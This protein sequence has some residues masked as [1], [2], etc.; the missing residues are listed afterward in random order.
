MSNEEIASRLH[1]KVELL[2]MQVLPKPTCAT[3]QQKWEW[4]KDDV[5]KKLAVKLN[6]QGN[7]LTITV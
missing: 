3:K 4:D 6:P 2:I 7:G 5:K 1:G